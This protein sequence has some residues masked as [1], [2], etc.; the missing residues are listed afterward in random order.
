MKLLPFHRP[1]WRVH[2]ARPPSAA[3]WRRSSEPSSGISASNRPVMAGPTPGT[4]CE[5][6]VLLAPDR[7]GLDRLADL[8]VEVG[9]LALQGREQALDARQHAPVGAM[10]SCAAV[11]ATIIATIW[12][13]RP[14]RSLN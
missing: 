4:L 11:S 5:Q 10:L 1:D 14:T 8:P 9:E 12:L 3:I 2:G 6:L 7:R 13:R